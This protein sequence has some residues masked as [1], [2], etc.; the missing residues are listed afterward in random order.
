MVESA[1]LRPSADAWLCGVPPTTR[2]GSTPTAI[3]F[4][5]RDDP[6]FSC[7]I[8]RG[9]VT[10][11]GILRQAT[12]DDLLHA[13]VNTGIQ[14]RDPRR[15]LGDDRRHRLRGGRA[16]ERHATRH[17]L[18]QHEPEGKLVRA[19]IDVPAGGLLR[20]HVLDGAQ[21]RSRTGARVG[22][23]LDRFETGLV[24]GEGC[25]QL[26][27]AEIQDLG[28][29]VPGHHHVF[30]LQVPVDDSRRVRFGQAVRDLRRHVDRLRHR[31][32]AGL[33]QCSQ[34]LTLDQLHGDVVNPVDLPDVVDRDDVRMVQ[35]GGEARFPF[36]ALQPLAIGGEVVRQ[37]LDRD[38]TPELEVAGASLTRAEEWEPRDP[39][40]SPA[41]GAPPRRRSH[42][43][44][45][46]QSPCARGPARL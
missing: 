7:E 33:E 36:E 30:G 37:N 22:G 32:E 43:A 40:P 6:H 26:S 39:R 14:I 3:V 25:G 11:S 24:F 15:L 29:A 13:F 42:T 41:R 19:E 38:V 5:F 27:Q 8:E 2:K 16:I 1:A 31:K 17:H 20:R 9:G 45:L 10:L 4:V 12:L 34:R 28:E 21:D 35:A 23:G 18:V 44:S 46:R